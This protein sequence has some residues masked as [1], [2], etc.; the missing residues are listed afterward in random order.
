MWAA[1]KRARAHRHRLPE[2]LYPVCHGLPIIIADGL[3]GTDETLVPVEGGEYV[4]EAKIGQALMDADIVISLTHF[5]GHE[6]AGFGGAMKNL[7]MGGGSRWQDGTTCRRQAKRCDRAL[8]WL[9][10]LRKDLCAQRHLV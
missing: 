7:G 8:R 9:P 2:W 6:Q 10:C 4:R 3:K 1:A 5:K